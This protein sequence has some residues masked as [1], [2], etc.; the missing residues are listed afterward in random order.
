MDKEKPEYEKVDSFQ[1]R[2][3]IMWA[4]MSSILKYD[5]S[6][7]KDLQQNVLMKLTR[8]IVIQANCISKELNGNLAY[9]VNS[10]PVL[11]QA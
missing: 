7:T 9:L 1:R 4:W 3:T 10:K 8:C 5:K 11:T 6:E 2:L